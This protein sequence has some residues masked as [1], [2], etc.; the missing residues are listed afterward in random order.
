MSKSGKKYDPINKCKSAGIIPYTYHNNKLMFLLQKTEH[1][2]SNKNNGWNDF[3]GRQNHNEHTFATAAREFSEETSC[4]FYVKEF[5]KNKYLFNSLKN[6]KSLF[7]DSETVSMLRKILHNSQIYFTNK[8]LEYNYP[9]F[10]SSQETYISFFL[11]VIYIPKQHIPNAEDIHIDYNY[12]YKRSCEWFT[13]DQ[14]LKLDNSSLHKRL[15][16]T[17][18]KTKVQFLYENE[19]F[20]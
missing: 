3:G 1:P 10:V 11:K 19:F 16:I 17:N 15:Q 7:Y 6:K 5:V 20:I 18:L 8:L 9:L 2:N 4:L 13:L 14:L 12:R